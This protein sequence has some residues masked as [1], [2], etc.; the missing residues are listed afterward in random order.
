[1]RRTLAL[2]LV[3][4]LGLL[5]APTRGGACSCA[6]RGPFLTVAREAPLVVR[7]RILRLHPG[8]T[9]T[10]DVLVLET[11]A[12]G[13]LD[14]GLVVQMGD[15][16]HCRP[17]LD[18]FPPGSEWVL[19]LNGPGAKPGTGLALSHCGEFWLGVEN[20]IVKGSID[21]LQNQIN[22]MPW[23]E[24]KARLLYPA[25]G[26][27]ISGQIAAGDRFCRPFGSRFEFILEP[28]LSGWEIV[29]R[30]FGRTENLSRL[31]PPLHSAPNPREIEGW[32]LTGKPGDC[33][34]RPYQAETGP[35]NPREFIFAPEVGEG[36]DG[37][38]AGRS[39]T[40]EDVEKVR[41]FGRGTLFIEAF[42]L[43]PGGNGCP[44]IEWLKFSAQLE[45]GY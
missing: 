3:F 15:G 9:S 22:W 5:A 10:M 31:T 18:G 19:A 27:K 26:E 37:E 39:I 43:E 21:G 40:A 7:A 29:V 13:L 25:F 6:W 24:F 33:S 16:M 41:C 1:M 20:G 14:S 36:I 23:P 32:H 38:K 8:A 11:L 42:K 28:T 30:E 4:G 34:S 12:G 17:M 35:A 44:K 2:C 45:G